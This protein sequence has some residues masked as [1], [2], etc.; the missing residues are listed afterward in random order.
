[1]WGEAHTH[2]RIIESKFIH[3]G[4]IIHSNGRVEAANLFHRVQLTVP[5]ASPG[6]V[7]FGAIRSLQ[8]GPRNLQA[9]ARFNF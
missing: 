4:D 1:V 3:H 5:A 6:A 7:N 2:L 9:A 8:S